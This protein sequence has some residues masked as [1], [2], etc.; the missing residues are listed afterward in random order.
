MELVLCRIHVKRLITKHAVYEKRPT[1]RRSCWY[2]NAEVLSRFG[3]EALPVPCQWK[4]LTQG[5]HSAREEAPGGPG[6][7]VASSP[8]PQA[9]AATP[10]SSSASSSS[11]AKRKSAGSMSIT[12]FMRK[13][14]GTEQ[15]GAKRLPQTEV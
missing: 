12:K 8:G 15:V 6:M 14:R 10:T 1:Y 13:C 11:S 3:Q 9:S 2:A 7:Q 4:Y 5:P